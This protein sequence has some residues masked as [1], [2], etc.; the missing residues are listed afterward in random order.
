MLV[1]VVR[2]VAILSALFC[3]ICSCCLCPM[4]AVTIWGCSKKTQSARGWNAAD[5]CTNCVY[6]T[7]APRDG[8]PILGPA[9][10]RYMPSGWLLFTKAGDVVKSWPYDT[11]KLTPVIWICDLCNTQ[12][13]NLNQM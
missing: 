2:P 6:T 3:V 10:R 1:S 4:L 7:P 9:G 8:D 12:A 13:T 5:I 11:N